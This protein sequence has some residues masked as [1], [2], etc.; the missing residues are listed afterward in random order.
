MSR[1]EACVVGCADAFRG[2]G[3]ILASP[4]GPVPLVAAKLARRTFEPGLMLSDGVATLI[5]EEG[6]VEGWMPYRRVFDVVWRGR[7][8]V[9]MGATQIDR[10]GNQNISCLGDFQRPKVQLLGV[11]GAPG[12]T[13]HH[14]TSYWVPRHSPRV[15]VP[16]V[17]VVCGVGYDKDAGPFH[18]IRVV[19]S[20][21][22][23]FD[24]ET[25]DHRMRVRSL[26]RA[27]RSTRSW[28]GRGSSWSFQSRSPSRDW[29]LKGS[30]P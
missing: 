23:V 19:V 26:H 12:N 11:R 24:F 20:D 14:V 27:F 8:H 7:R 1:F 25:P 6:A 13:V 10:Y 21:L 16:A 15:F 4:M 5:D 30:A 3:E 18:E 22:G 17:D 28:L 2:D 9:M 29:P